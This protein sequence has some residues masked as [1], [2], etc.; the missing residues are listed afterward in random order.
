MTGVLTRGRMV[1][2]LL[3]CFGAMVAICLVAPLVG[4]DNAGGA[5]RLVWIDLGA[6]VD[7]IRGPET[8]ESQ[9]FVLAR[10][11]RVLTGAV[12]GAGLAVAGCV[13]QALLRNP[14]AA[15]YSLGVSSGASLAAVL[16]IR[17][18]LDQT[19]LGDSAIGL[20]A[21]AGAAVTVYMVW[22]LA[23]IGSDLPPAMLL[24]AGVI[25]T[26]VCSSAILLVHY[27]ASFSES[28]RF[29]RW[30]M[31]GLEW[32]RYPQLLRAAIPSAIGVFVLMTLARDLNALSAGADAAASVGVDPRRTTTIGFFAA[33]LVVGAGISVA[34]P[35]GFVG[36]IVPHAMRGVLGPDHRVL[37]PASIFIG[38][39]FVVLCDTV[40]RL[41]LYPAELPVGVVTTL[42]GGGFALY[43]IIGKRTRARLWGGS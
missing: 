40:A 35:I 9:L 1:G 19:A 24:L 4:M 16:A 17:F 10:L 29:V 6:V 31:G 41:A 33:S 15:P 21:L 32:I 27:T 39:A 22:K 14:L 38:A 18:G 37:V 36:L 8:L 2:V 5:R 3:A 12:V 25:V 20:A 34:G 28:Y 13:F 30:T 26:I 42:L 7:G 43:L 11:P 23:Q